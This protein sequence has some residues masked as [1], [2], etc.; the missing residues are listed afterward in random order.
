MK[1]IK[2]L[3][4]W[5]AALLFGATVV[6]YVDRQ[7]LSLLAPILRDQL[8]ISNTD[9]SRIIFAFLLAYMVM[10][11]VSGRL[12]DRLGTRCGLALTI[13]LWSVAAALHATARSAAGFGVF[14]FLLGI[15]EAGNWP[16]AV[17]AVAEWFPARE[18]ALATGFFNS[19]SIVGAMVAAPAVPWIALRYGW[20]A[21]FVVTGML[22]FLWLVPWLVLYRL[23]TESHWITSEELRLL[24]KRGS[25]GDESTSGPRRWR[26]LLTYRPVWGL[27]FCRMLADPIWWFY[28]FWLP[29]YLARERHF[30]LSMIG[31]SVW[32]PFL[33]AGIGSFAGGLVSGL[34]VARGWTPVRA[35]KAVMLAGAILM[36]AGTLA[37][38][39]S[40]A[41]IALALISTA[42]FA[43]ACWATNVLSLPG[44]L[45]PS[46][47]V[48]SVSGL[49]GTGGALGGMVFTLA[50][51][52]LL[53]RFSYK[54]VFVIAGFMA[55][56][57]GAVLMWTIRE[58][59]GPAACSAAGSNA[60]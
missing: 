20:Q 2:H 22:G 41:S 55:I 14:R 40:R 15:G 25:A 23:P 28:V 29:E 52:A 45:F 42:T 50:T 12:M 11:G 54:P 60:D 46:R 18:R 38:S 44:D 17:K 35:R 34:L 43:Y 27:V 36:L 31:N 8:R 39:A 26:E 57:A 58:S 53:D 21:A 3:R 6:N 10:Q 33:T 24:T 59:Y 56:G 37:V 49:S 51:G 48:A 19:G 16:G 32:I 47:V 9:Y 4:W 13:S 30:T 5:I 7:V 1:P